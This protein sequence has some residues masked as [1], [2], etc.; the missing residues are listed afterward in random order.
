MTARYFEITKNAGMIDGNNVLNEDVATLYNGMALTMNT[1][2]EL[3]I[4]TDAANRIYGLAYEGQQLNDL[5]TTEN[6]AT[7][8][9]GYRIG[10]VRGDF[11]A[12]CNRQLFEGTEIPTA[13]QKIWSTGDGTL[14][15]TQPYSA[16]GTPVALGYC[17]GNAPIQND[18]DIGYS[19]RTVAR[20]VFSIDIGGMY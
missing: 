11:E 3:I 17:V 18:S 8:N 13:T 1:S 4:P 6:I 12:L 2:A 14:T 7:D 5:P 15:A 9:A 16:S 10:V 19:Y 20:V